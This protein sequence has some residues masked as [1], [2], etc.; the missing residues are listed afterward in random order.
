MTIWI[1]PWQIWTLISWSIPFPQG[2][3]FSSKIWP[4]H[5]LLQKWVVIVNCQEQRKYAHP[6]TLL[7]IMVR[8]NFLSFSFDNGPEIPNKGSEPSCPVFILLNWCPFVFWKDLFF[9]WSL[10]MIYILE[11][12]ASLPRFNIYPSS[13]FKPLCIT[14]AWDHMAVWNSVDFFFMEYKDVGIWGQ[15]MSPFWS[16]FRHP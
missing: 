4:I 12:R 2:L 5:H 10:W 3:Y 8:D 16:S 11:V 9:F 7:K 15:P 6:G 14:G 1:C 13:C